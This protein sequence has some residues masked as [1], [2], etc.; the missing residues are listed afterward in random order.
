[1][2]WGCYFMA[3]ADN[4]VY[5]DK[6]GPCRAYCFASDNSLASEER[7]DQGVMVWDAHSEA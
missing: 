2:D 6:R 5:P 7:K 3:G 4:V 1:M